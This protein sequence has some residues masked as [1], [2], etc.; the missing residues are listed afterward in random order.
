[1]KEI[2]PESVYRWIEAQTIRP[3]GKIC[4]KDLSDARLK[5]ALESDNLLDRAIAKQLLELRRYYK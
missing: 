5:K 4:W 1:M 3:G 2:L